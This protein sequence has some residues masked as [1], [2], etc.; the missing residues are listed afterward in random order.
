MRRLMVLALILVST[1]CTTLRPVNGTPEDLR[2]QISAGTLLKPGDR[3]SIVSVDGKTHRFEVT[4]IAA[5]VIQGRHESVPVDQVASL[6]KRR[7]SA[8]KTA[9]L[10]VA[11]VAAGIVAIAAEQGP[12]VHLSGGPL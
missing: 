9:A 5:G 7:V 10:A 1:G 11:V 3:V 2:Q 12:R 6:E 4:G 8:L